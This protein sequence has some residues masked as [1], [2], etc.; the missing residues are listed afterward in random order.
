MNNEFKFLGGCD[1][2]PMHLLYF[3]QDGQWID[4]YVQFFIFTYVSI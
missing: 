2:S 3:I 1:D 4:Y